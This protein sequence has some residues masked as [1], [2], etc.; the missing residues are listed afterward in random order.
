MPNLPDYCHDKEQILSLSLLVQKC[1][2]IATLVCAH[3]SLYGSISLE[4][5]LVLSNLQ[6]M[7]YKRFVKQ[8]SA[9][10]QSQLTTLTKAFKAY[11]PKGLCSV[12]IVC[13]HYAG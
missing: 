7:D 1:I 4:I 8:F 11:S 2:C 13:N 5:N 10:T 6:D 9:F 12:T 3:G